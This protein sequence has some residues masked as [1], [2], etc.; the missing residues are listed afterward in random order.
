MWKRT[1]A[2]GDAKQGAAH[3]GRIHDIILFYGKTSELTFQTHY[4]PY[5]TEYI[6]SHYRYVE[7]VTGR[8]YRKGDLTANKPGGDTEYEWKG[9]RP[10]KGRYWAYSKEK[11]EQFEQQ[12]RLVYTKTGMPEDKRYLDEM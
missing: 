11:M 6:E 12:G 5:D 3:Y 1:S 10:Y 2:H 7:A 8:R 4:Q 9:V